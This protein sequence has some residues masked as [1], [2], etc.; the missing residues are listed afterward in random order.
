MTSICGAFD[1]ALA[2]TVAVVSI[3]A[4]LFGDR[5]QGACI[6]GHVLSHNDPFRV[7]AKLD[8]EGGNL[9]QHLICLDF[10]LRQGLPE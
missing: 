1:F 9:I 5:L 6:L 4:L 2:V 8:L 7:D 3:A 10:D